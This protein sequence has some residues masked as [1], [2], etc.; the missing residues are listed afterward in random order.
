V[1]RTQSE[2]EQH[3]K[4]KVQLSKKMKEESDKHRDWVN[5]TNNQIKGFE[6][7]QRVTRIKVKRLQFCSV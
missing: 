2:I 1:L 6:K 5:K 7:D 4:E 3:R